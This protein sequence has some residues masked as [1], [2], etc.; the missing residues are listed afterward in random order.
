MKITY[1]YWQHKNSGEVFAIK[2]LNE[3]VQFVNGPLYYEDYENNHPSVYE[4]DEQVNENFDES[5]FK[6]YEK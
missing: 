3:K 2:L 1:Q 6:L 4:Y 5:E